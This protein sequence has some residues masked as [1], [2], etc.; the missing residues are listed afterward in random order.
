MRLRENPHRAA[1]EALYRAAV[2]AGRDPHAYL[3]LAVPD[4]IDGR[5]DMIGLH[6][7]LLIRRLGDLPPPGLDVA[8]ALFDAMFL[9]MDASLRELGVG[10]PSM[11]RRMRIMWNAFNG[12]LHAYASSLAS[13]DHDALAAAL[14]RNVWRGV[15]PPGGATGE[16]A[17]IAVA[18]DRAL[19]AADP[20]RLMAGE[21]HF[22]A[23][24]EALAA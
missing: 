8:Q 2:T 10:D 21:V 22:L 24:A 15:A 17:R 14:L 19:A 11:A 4:T 1:G 12:R 20:A 3:E 18:Q 5:F 7:A 13:G 6:A 16:L 23:P 9:D